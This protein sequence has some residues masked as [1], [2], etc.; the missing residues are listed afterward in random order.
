MRPKG[1]N[2]T[3]YSVMIEQLYLESA[4]KRL[5]EY[6]ALGDK[7]FIQL[8]TAQMNWQLNTS[9]NSIAIIIQHLHGNMLSRWSNFLTEDGEKEWRK[10]DDE[11][12]QQTHSKEDLIDK[13]EKGWQVVIE[14]IQSLTG[15]DLSRTITIRSQPLIVVDAINRQ[16]AH[17]SYHVGQIVYLGKCLCEENWQSLS[18]PKGN[19]NAFNEQ[20]KESN[21]S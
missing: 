8:D 6:K 13:W 3:K 2:T 9:S 1:I 12:E 17:Y 18:I 20:M 11:F 10:R 4:I 15:D 7:T 19:S 16:L 14:T 5:K 21:K